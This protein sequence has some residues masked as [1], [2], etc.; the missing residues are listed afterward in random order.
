MY[1]ELRQVIKGRLGEDTVLRLTTDAV[2]AQIIDLCASD[3]RN[4][5]ETKINPIPH[6]H[7]LSHLQVVLMQLVLYEGWLLMNQPKV[8]K[9]LRPQG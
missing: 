2:F 3:A 8:M 1:E 6:V 9:A 4:Q 5:Q 7:Q